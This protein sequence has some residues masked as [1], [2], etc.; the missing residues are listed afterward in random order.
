MPKRRSV[1]N[2]I[3]LVALKVRTVIR[4][5]VRLA[6]VLLVVAVVYAAVIFWTVY[7]HH[8]PQDRPYVE[9]VTTRCLGLDGL[10]VGEEFGQ[11][12][13]SGTTEDTVVIQSFLPSA[14]P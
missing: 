13:P 11:P 8:S 1:P 4:P 3:E 12:C 14:P 5:F 7:V 10:P 2:G 9:V 6:L